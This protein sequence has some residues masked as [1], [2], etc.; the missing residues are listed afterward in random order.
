MVGGVWLGFRRGMGLVGF[1]VLMTVAP[2]LSSLASWVLVRR[3]LPRTCLRWRRP[4]AALFSQMVR[5]SLSTLVFSMGT[6]ILYQT[7]KLVAAWR[8]GGAEAA[9]HMGLAVSIVQSLGVL[10]FPGLHA[11]LSRITQLHGEGRPEAIRELLER[12]L[13]ATGLL[14]IPSVAFLIQDAE[15]LFQA[16]LGSTVPPEAIAPLGDTSRLLLVGQGAYVLTLPCYY[17]LLGTGRH[18]LFGVAMLAI[19]VANAIF[20]WVAAGLLPR[21]ETLGFVSG[22][23]SLGLSALVTFP[24]ALRRFPVPVARLLGRCLGVPLLALLPGVA[25][26]AWRPRLG[27]PIMDLVLDAALFAVLAAPGLELAR[28]RY[29][30]G[31]AL[32]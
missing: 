30:R 22:V 3:L 12:S 2:L 1:V 8:C 10:F 24:V 20:G 11:L 25:G 15:L 17:A 13:I 31:A 5:H 9:G 28:R 27:P 23:L 21:I 26:V 14:V 7:M 18:V 32:S 29:L 16:W 19:V 4:D 6:V